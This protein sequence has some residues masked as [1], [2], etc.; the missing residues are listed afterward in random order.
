MD[1]RD[2]NRSFQFIGMEYS[3]A[4]MKWAGAVYWRIF[5]LLIRFNLLYAITEYG[6]KIGEKM[7]YK[8]VT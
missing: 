4:R 5:S 6:F 7:F 1:I 2:A 3:N 8:W